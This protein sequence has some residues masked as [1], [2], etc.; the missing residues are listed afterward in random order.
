MNAFVVF[1]V[2]F[3]N[4]AEAS[5]GRPT[6]TTAAAVGEEPSRFERRSAGVL[7]GGG[8]PVRARLPPVSG[9]Y[10]VLGEP[11]EHE[12]H[13]ENGTRWSTGEAVNV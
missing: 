8:R 7:T 1:V 2:P 11:Q 13:L 10:A 6:A 4:R 3:E 12:E 9:G 5:S